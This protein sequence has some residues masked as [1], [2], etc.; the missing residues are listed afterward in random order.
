MVQYK[1]VD[2]FLGYIDEENLKDGKCPECGST[3][4]EKHCELDKPCKCGITIHETIKLCEKCGEPVCPKCNC[5]DVV[6]ISRITGYMS[7]YGGWSAG[8]KAEF[9]DR[10]RVNIE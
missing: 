1:C 2:C 10:Y 7:E 5:H 3:N 6:G 4:L 9:K 8:K